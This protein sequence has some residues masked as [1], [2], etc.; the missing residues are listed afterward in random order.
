M[1]QANQRK[2][3]AAQGKPPK[4]A[5]KFTKT[6]AE[7]FGPKAVRLR[8]IRQQVDSEGREFDRMLD[9]VFP[10]WSREPG[11]YV[12]IPEETDGL[13]P[14]VYRISDLKAKK[15]TQAQKAMPPEKK[16]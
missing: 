8:A 12:L 6:Q 5:F 7:L 2:K 15:P 10:A 14:G 1:G 9:L 13:V 3:Q 16:K 11:K 4:P